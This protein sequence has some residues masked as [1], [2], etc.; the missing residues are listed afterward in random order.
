MSCEL[1]PRN[2]RGSEK[3]LAFSKARFLPNQTTFLDH[4]PDAQIVCLIERIMSK[5]PKGTQFKPYYL[6]HTC[7][8][9]RGIETSFDCY[10]HY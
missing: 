3:F 8:S 9:E 2:S 6:H 1:K 4:F 7:F 10:R 5:L